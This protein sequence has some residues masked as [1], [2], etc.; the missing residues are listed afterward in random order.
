MPDTAGP[1]CRGHRRR[2]G[3]RPDEGKIMT[4]RTSRAIGAWGTAAR[5][6]GGLAFPAAVGAGLWWRAHRRPQP[7]RATGPVGHAAN[8]AALLGPYLTWWYTPAVMAL[9]DAVRA[10]LAARRGGT[11]QRR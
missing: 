6:L 4:V 1:G 5:L 8:L 10:R 2:A 9:S 3:A 11:P 7:L